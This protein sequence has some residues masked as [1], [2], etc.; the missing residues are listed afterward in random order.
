MKTMKFELKTTGEIAQALAKRMR[1]L[2]LRKKWKRMTLADRSGVSNSSLRR[3]EQTGKISLESFL[4]LMS[5]FDR[6]FEM[7]KL[8]QPLAVKSI[9]DL[10][11]RKK[12]LPKRGSI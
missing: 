4:K 7:E 11:M 9:D 10:E 8:L 2:R 12:K 5:T 3:F 1:E 6:L